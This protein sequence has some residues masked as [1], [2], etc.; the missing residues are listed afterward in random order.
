MQGKAFGSSPGYPPSRLLI[1]VNW[2]ANWFA[3]V[4]RSTCT[5]CRTPTS[6]EWHVNQILWI[7][8]VKP[9]KIGFYGNVSWVI[10]TKFTVI[11]YARGATNPENLAKIGRVHFEV[12]GLEG[13][14]KI[15]SNSSSY[16][17]LR[18]LKMVSYWYSPSIVTI[19]LSHAISEI[20]VLKK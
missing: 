14:V 12:I 11:I 13:I 20:F 18:A 9:I 4:K 5:S 19:C 8:P 17:S 3:C 6:T 1:I 2:S 10:A 15:R 7:W 16:G